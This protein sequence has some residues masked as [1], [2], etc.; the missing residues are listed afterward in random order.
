MPD[1]EPETF[2]IARSIK[3]C[4]KPNISVI[5]FYYHNLF[6]KYEQ[7]VYSLVGTEDD[8]TN[9][10]NWDGYNGNMAHP[11]PAVNF[12]AGQAAPIAFNAGFD[13]MNSNMSSD[14]QS[15]DPLSD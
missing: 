12:M 13:L 8:S 7:V 4:D 10:D 11:P 15:D 3:L 14:Q 2:N 5:H 6:H 9:N 1:P